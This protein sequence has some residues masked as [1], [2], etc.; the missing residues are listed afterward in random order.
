MKLDTMS[1]S[2]SVYYDRFD[3]Q[4]GR[5]EIHPVNPIRHAAETKTINVFSSR[6]WHAFKSKN[7]A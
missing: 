4:N 6:I 1:S 5:G 2:S 3:E 7:S